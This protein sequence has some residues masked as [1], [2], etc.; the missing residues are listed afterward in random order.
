MM[1]YFVDEEKE[2][3]FFFLLLSP[4]PP[5][6]PREMW[7]RILSEGRSLITSLVMLA[8]NACSYGGGTAACD[9]G[10][11]EQVGVAAVVRRDCTDERKDCRI[12]VFEE[13]MTLFEET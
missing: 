5:P 8:L 13:G 4:P 1:G 10:R 6:P 2:D 3:S 7:K 12:V 9:V 11:G